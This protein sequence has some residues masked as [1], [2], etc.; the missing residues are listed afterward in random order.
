MK[1]KE[2]FYSIQGEGPLSGTPALFIRFGGCNLACAW[3]DTDHE[4]KLLHDDINAHD[5]FTIVQERHP[6]NGLVVLTGGEPLTQPMPELTRLILLLDTKGYTVQI[7]TNGTMPL[8]TLLWD[9]QRVTVVC[10]PK[11]GTIVHPTILARIAV[12]KFVLSEGQ[13][14]PQDLVSHIIGDVYVQPMDASIVP[15]QELRNQR[16]LDWCISY[17][18]QNGYRLSVQLHKMLGLA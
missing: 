16:N 6:T 1:V 17:S 12:W 11:E 7:E 18:M 4:G 2:I 14:V 13:E 3:C 9:K 15:N 10:S 8:D 5:L